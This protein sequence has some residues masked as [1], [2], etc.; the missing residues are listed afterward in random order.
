MTFIGVRARVW[1]WLTVVVMTIFP[2]LNAFY[3]DVETAYAARLTSRSLTLE[4]NGGATNGTGGSAPGGLANH[5]FKFTVPTSTT[6]KSVGFLYCTTPD[7][8]CTTPSGLSTTSAAFSFVAGGT[9]GWTLNNTTNGAPYIHDATGA[10]LTTANSGVQEIR[11]TGI[12]NPNTSAPNQAFYVRITTYTGS[13]GATGPTDD[14]VVAASVADTIVVTGTMPE[15]LLFCSGGTVTSDCVTVTSGAISFNADF[16]PSTS[17]YTTSEF[18]AATNASSGYTIVA[19]GTTLK[20]TTSGGG[21]TIPVVGGTATSVAGDAGVSHFGIN[22]VA[23]TTPSVG[24]APGSY[25][26]ANHLYQPTVNFGTANSY[27]LDLTTP[28][29]IAKSDNNGSS[30]GTGTPLPTYGQ[31][32]T[33]SYFA[34]V[35]QIQAPGTYKAYINYVCTPTF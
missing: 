27:A 17:V 8:S 28:A 31:V 20:N 4:Q 13:D 15:Y 30:G 10:N 24:A 11:L 5:H 25:N 14:G 23:N 18:S 9:S 35:S 22:T 32:V 21:E 29:T 6:V 19:T 34:N 33:V 26:T 12:T 2:L 7:G 3:W 16:T 1:L